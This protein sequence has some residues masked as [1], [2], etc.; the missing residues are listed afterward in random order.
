MALYLQC[1]T[2]QLPHT[3][4]Q[5][6]F[7]PVVEL[8]ADKLNKLRVAERQEVNDLVNPSQ[9]LVTSELGLKEQHTNRPSVTMTTQ[10]MRLHHQFIYYGHG[11]KKLVSDW[12][13]TVC[14][15]VWCAYICVCVCV[16]DQ[17]A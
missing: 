12:L 7:G 17:T 6:L 2:F 9:K 5:Y 10:P 8:L 11:K 14:V 4:T 13:E 16:S 15:C 3:H 1:Y